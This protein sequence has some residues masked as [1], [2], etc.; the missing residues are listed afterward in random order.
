MPVTAPKAFWPSIRLVISADC[1][2]AWNTAVIAKTFAARVAYAGTSPPVIPCDIFEKFLVL[3]EE[4]CAVP[5][6]ARSAVE[7]DRATLFIP[8]PSF[9]ADF[10]VRRILPLSSTIILTLTCFAIILAHYG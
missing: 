7:A 10:S 8:P 2:K 4:A 1:L 9:F 5:F 3:L 6:K